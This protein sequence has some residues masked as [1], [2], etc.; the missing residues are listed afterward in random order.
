MN[1][2]CNSSYQMN[3]NSTQLRKKGRVKPLQKIIILYTPQKITIHQSN[4]NKKHS[5]PKPEICGLKQLWFLWIMRNPKY[6]LVNHLVQINFRNKTP[7]PI[8]RMRSFP[9]SLI[10]IFIG[11]S[12]TAMRSI[13][14]I[15][16]LRIGTWGKMLRYEANSYS[17]HQLFTYPRIKVALF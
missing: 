14:W 7:W 17:S 4:H 15:K 13:S 9:Q 11:S 8:I 10:K 2:W 6:L 3:S 5:K 1:K 16:T 12:G